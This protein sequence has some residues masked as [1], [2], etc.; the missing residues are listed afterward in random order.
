MQFE[1]KLLINGKK[2]QVKGDKRTEDIIKE[3]DETIE[4]EIL[5]EC[6]E[7]GG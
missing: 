4:A 3:I 6:E 7:Y 1:A 5:K 2:L